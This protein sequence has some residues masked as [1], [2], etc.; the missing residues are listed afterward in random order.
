[1]LTYIRCGGNGHA[2]GT[3]ADSYSNESLQVADLYEMMTM[4][5]AAEGYSTVELDDKRLNRRLACL[6][7]ELHRRRLVAGHVVNYFGTEAS[8]K[9]SVSGVSGSAMN[10]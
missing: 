6:T 4:G 9:N 5:W 7:A 1:M 10:P 8:G 2:R 3:Q